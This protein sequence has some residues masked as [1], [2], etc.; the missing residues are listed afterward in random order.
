LQKEIRAYGKIGRIRAIYIK[1]S[2]EF[3][4]FSPDYP[5]TVS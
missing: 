4:Q 3:G 5:I 1:D 2:E